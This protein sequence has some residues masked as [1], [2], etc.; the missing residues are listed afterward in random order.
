MFAVRE[1]V[2]GFLFLIFFR[3][4]LCGVCCRRGGGGFTLC[5]GKVVPGERILS[6]FRYR[7]L[8]ASGM[9]LVVPLEYI[10]IAASIGFTVE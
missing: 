1:R 6:C 3:E 5:A 9:L 10:F 4:I 8:G 7:V 2:F